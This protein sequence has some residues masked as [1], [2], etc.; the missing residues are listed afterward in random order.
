VAGRKREGK[1]KKGREAR[2]NIKT[3]SRSKAYR[4]S[5]RGQAELVFTLFKVALQKGIRITSF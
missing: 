2:G 1:V 3:L 4:L 5:S